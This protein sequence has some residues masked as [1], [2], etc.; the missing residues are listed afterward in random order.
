MIPIEWGARL[1]R[2]CLLQ[3]RALCIGLLLTSSFANAGSTAPIDEFFRAVR[4]ANINGVDHFIHAEGDLAAVNAEGRHALHVSVRYGHV[5]IVRLLLAAGAA[6]DARDADSWTALH[7]AA[8][9]GDTELINILLSAGA[10]VTASDDYRY[11]P[12][13]L[14]AREG[15]DAACEILLAAGADPHAVIDVGFTAA[16]VGL[17]AIDNAGTDGDLAHAFHTPGDHQ[18]LGTRHHGLGGEGLQEC[19]NVRFKRPNFLSAHRDAANRLPTRHK[20]HRQECPHAF[21]ID[22]CPAQRIA[23]TIGLRIGQIFHVGNSA[24]PYGLRADCTA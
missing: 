18:I 5:E 21:I 16:V 2:P 22:H 24:L 17:G 15:H 12:L 6:V 14:A 11:A 1:A 3:G 10:S 8:E 9:A 23:I 7:F 13:H 19:D 20:R 4:L